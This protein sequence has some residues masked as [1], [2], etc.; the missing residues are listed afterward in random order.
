M[1]IERIEFD[2]GTMS[3]PAFLDIYLEGGRRITMMGKDAKRNK[4]K[5]KVGDTYN[6]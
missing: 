1:K 3:A 4:N 6:G 2:A 5:Y